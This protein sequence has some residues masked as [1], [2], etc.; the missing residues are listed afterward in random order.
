MPCAL[1]ACF[2]WRIMESRACR[3]SRHPNYFGEVTMWAGV[4]LSSTAVLTGWRLLG[5]SCVP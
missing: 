2:W 3:F 1:L 5:A 4:F